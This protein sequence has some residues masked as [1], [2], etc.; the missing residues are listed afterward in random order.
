MDG[1]GYYNYHTA[2][3][4][5]SGEAVKLSHNGTIKALSHAKAIE[6]HVS[7]SLNKAK[8]LK[9]Y[10]ESGKWSGKTRDA[11]LSYLELIIDLNAD[12]KDALEDHTS[13][14]NVLEKSIDDFSKLSEV[15]EI[16]NL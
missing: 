12:M 6:K 9:S 13:A 1:Y 7:D 5:V 8:E 2:E 11:F 15:K 3:S 10:V 16:Q 14:L 4:K